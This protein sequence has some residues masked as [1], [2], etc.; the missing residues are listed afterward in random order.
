MACLVGYRELP[1]LFRKCLSSYID[2]GCRCLVVGIDGNDDQDEQM[3]QIFQETFQ[4]NSRIGII[5]LPQCVGTMF[6]EDASHRTVNCERASSAHKGMDEPTAFAKAYDFLKKEVQR[7]GCLEPSLTSQG[8]TAICFTQPHRDLKE[9]RLSAW[10]LS[11]VLADMYNIEYLWSSD[12][13]TIVAKDCVQNAFKIMVS[14]PKA[15]GVSALVQI[16]T[17]NLPIISRMAETAFAFDVYLNRAALAATCRSECLIGA[18]SMFRIPALREVAVP[19][20]RI[21]YPGSC[22]LT[23]INED[24]QI[25]MLLAAKGWHRLYS[26]RSVILTT[27]P[28]TIRGWLGQRVRWSRALNLHLWYDFHYIFS[29]GPMY[30]AY[31]YKAALYD[32]LLWLYFV[33]YAITG[34]KLLQFSVSDLLLLEVLPPFYNWLRTPGSLSA[35]PISIALYFLYRFFGPTVKMYALLT[36]FDQSWGLSRAQNGLTTLGSIVYEREMAFLAVWIL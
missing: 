14:E 24:I 17:T 18:G 29:Q 5:H 13:D 27:G 22:T 34:Q 32:V 21:Q 35:K 33:Y 15:G 31:W 16:A 2:A 30:L 3:L 23:T 1:D 28:L 25:T 12:S 20:Y 8:F 9:I 11:I 26:E 10:I 7:L 36:P 6:V 19:W 4:G